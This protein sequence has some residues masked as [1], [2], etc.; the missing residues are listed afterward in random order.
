M[1]SE[2]LD[3]WPAL[4]TYFFRLKPK[5]EQDYDRLM[6]EIRAAGSGICGV[7]QVEVAERFVK[8]KQRGDF[9]VCTCCREGYPENDG[10][11]CRVCQGRENLYVVSH[12]MKQMVNHQ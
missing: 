1:D 8:K 12:A 10:P 2:K 11:L 7:E 6:K 5:K 3:N 9:A 4:K